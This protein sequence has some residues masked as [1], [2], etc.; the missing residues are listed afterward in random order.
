MSTFVGL[1]PACNDVAS[2]KN[3]ALFFV[4]PH[5]EA[6]VS[7]NEARRY[8]DALCADPAGIDNVL[9]MCFEMQE[10]HGPEIPMQILEKLQTFHPHSEK[11]AY[12]YV[13]MSGYRADLVRIYLKN[14]CAAKKVVPFAEDF[15][16]N[17]MSPMHGIMISQFAQYIEN[18][19]PDER[20]K[21]YLER[22]EILKSNYVG[23]SESG[24]GM[25]LMYAFYV[26]AAA[27]NVGLAVMFCLLSLHVGFHVL[28]AVGAFAVEVLL[29]FWHNRTY[30]NRIGISPRERI[31][32]VIFLSS[33]VVTVAG[34][35][36]GW[37]I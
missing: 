32:L 35:V 25:G 7:A 33:I 1:C 15:L 34:I 20:K 30:G 37:V 22:L 27:V 9:H 28:I 18:K 3:K 5:C 36:I 2:I 14:F 21:R 11:V 26:I 10:L 17:T 23:R 19:L 24:E 8:I 29:L 6:T 31:F 4:C 13:R 16:D 12:S